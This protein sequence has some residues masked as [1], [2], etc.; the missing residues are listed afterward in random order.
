MCRL[1]CP[2]EDMYP[3]LLLNIESYKSCVWGK[4]GPVYGDRLKDFVEC[5]DRT[6]SKSTGSTCLGSVVVTARSLT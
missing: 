6:R 3:L 2:L 5:S 1:M 4:K